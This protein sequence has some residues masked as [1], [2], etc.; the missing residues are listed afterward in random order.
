MTTVSGYGRIGVVP[1]ENAELTRVGF[2]TPMGEVLRR[3]W[4]PVCLSAEI[5]ELPRR[6]TI[7]G[8]E[9]VAFRDKRGRVGVLDAHCAHR[10]TSLEY[11]RIEDEGIRCCYH[12]WLYAADGTCLQQ[13]GEPPESNFRNKVSQP[14]YPAR[15]FGGLVF[16]YMGPP[17]KEPQLPRFDVLEQPGWQLFAYRNMSRGAVAECNWLQIQENAMDPVHTAFLHST[18]SSKQFTDIY[19]TLP[20]LAFEE[21]PYGM[22]YVRTAKLPSGRTFVRTQEAYTANM[23]SVADNLT[24]DRPYAERATLVGW[25]VP[26]DDTHTVGFHIE[27]F[28]PADKEKLSTFAR[29]KEGRTAGTQDKHR[30]YEDTQRNPDD[31]EAQVSQRPIAVHALERLG[32][33]DR[34]VI[35]FRKLLRRALQ[36]LKDGRDPQNVFREETI[37]KVVAGNRVK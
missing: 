35:M 29:A 36:D 17:D 1:K 18:I 32:T 28:D 34:G 23:R 3:Y 8:E 19:A 9:L 7:L 14:A 16:A 15:E 27:A 10:G 30:D 26:A 13:P 24:P 4:Q 2:G 20:E 11:G 22:K 33:T 31:K 12:G 25:W 21:T 37:I 6:V 5:D